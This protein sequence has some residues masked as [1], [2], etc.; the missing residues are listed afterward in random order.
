MGSSTSTL[1]DEYIPSLEDVLTVRDYLLGFVPLELAGMITDAAQYWPRATIDFKAENNVEWKVSASDSPRNVATGCCLLTPK[2]AD[3]IA[4]DKPAVVM[5]VRFTLVS[6]DQGWGGESYSGTSALWTNS[7]FVDTYLLDIYDGS[8]TWFEAVIV[9]DF[10]DDSVESPSS[11]RPPPSNNPHERET[12]IMRRIHDA[13]NTR[14]ETTNPKVITVKNTN[15]D[16]D[17][18]EL[19]RNRR[20]N[21]E[22]R[23][24]KI[25][26]TNEDAESADVPGAGFVQSLRMGDRIAVIAR[27]QYPGWVNH[28][29]SVEV[30]VSYSV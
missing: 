11:P 14:E 2:L 16:C 1:E 12:G 25:L 13:L 27:A 6:H 3:L 15:N 24:H 30:E 20:A 29:D 17:V 4:L 23:C 21:K 18:W 8:Y 10:I 9:R 28:V 7:S 26:W 19:Q 22:Y 5:A